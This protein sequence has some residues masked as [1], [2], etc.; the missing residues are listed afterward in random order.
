VKTGDI[1]LLLLLERREEKAGQEIS[2]DGGRA[3]ARGAA[4]W[5]GA[6]L[7]S[8]GGDG[9]TASQIVEGAVVAARARPGAARRAAAS[10]S[11]TV[12]GSHWVLR[13][14][15]F[16]C[17]GVQVFRCS[18]VQ[19]PNGECRRASIVRALLSIEILASGDRN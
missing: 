19:V 3:A 12:R 11:G 1:H 13:V 8:A 9:E 14:Q 10:E 17:S 4:V 18:G 16:R 2:A 7:A 15:V 5:D 6:P